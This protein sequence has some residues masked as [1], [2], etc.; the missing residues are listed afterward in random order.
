MELHFFALR[1]WNGL[2]CIIWL[3]VSFTSGL[4]FGYVS[5]RNM[6]AEL[7]V[8]FDVFGGWLGKRLFRRKRQWF[9]V[10]GCCSFHICKQKLSKWWWRILLMNLKLFFKDM[11]CLKRRRC[12]PLCPL[13][14][15][16]LKEIIHFSDQ[17]NELQLPCP[18]NQWKHWTKRL[19]W[20]GAK[21]DRLHFF[22]DLPIWT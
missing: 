19:W 22:E 4:G 13:T 12:L 5:T 18:W 20:L 15:N 10:C 3:E 14:W 1:K 8:M 9:H 11:N 2:N 6:A 16:P 17:V 21:C 7:P